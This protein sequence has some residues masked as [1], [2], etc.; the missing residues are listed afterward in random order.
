MTDLAQREAAPAARPSILRQPMA[1]WAVAF[2]SVIAFMGI[3]LV[4]PILPAIAR[5]LDATPSQTSLLFTSYMAVTGVAMLIT[6]VVSSRIGPRWTLLSGLA[7]IVVFAALA[8][9]SDSIGAIVGFRAGWGLG[10]ALFIATALATIV[11]AA[12]GGVASAII[13]YEAALGLGIAT[14]PLLGGVL[15]GISW[16][17]PFFGVA[18]LMAVAFVAILALLP[19]IPKATRTTSV[20]DPFRA[21][22]HRGL[23]TLGLTALFYNFGFFTLLAYTP[24]PLGMDAHGLGLVFF[25]WGLCLA[26]TSVFVA[27]RLQRVFGTLRT[28]YVNLAALAL[29]LVVMGFGVSSPATLVVCVVAAGL[30]L[31]INNTLIT[32]CVMEAAPVERG[33]ASAAYSFVRFIGG[34]IAPYLATKL[35]EEVNAEIPFYVG[36][37]GVGLAVVALWL[38]RGYLRHVDRHEP[39]E[40][41]PAEAA[42]MTAADAD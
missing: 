34:A 32:E 3:G 9:A 35:A 10:N 12:S 29:L 42:V 36:A 17:G 7:V 14:G 1:V 2:A 6:G 38:G 39:A 11:G 25:G 15:G 41:T 23:L 40:G 22:R 13:L 31:G 8:G 18:V 26:F 24:F 5:D 33:V 20:L 16:R 30:L 21:L 4:D 37:F 19:P 27:P 28:M